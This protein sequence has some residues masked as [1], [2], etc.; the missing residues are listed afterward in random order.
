MSTWTPS[1]L[2]KHDLSEIYLNG[3]ELVSIAEK[4]QKKK[5]SHVLEFVLTNTLVLKTWPYTTRGSLTLTFIIEVKVT[6]YQ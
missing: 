5:N 1:Y 3:D 6:L 4:A 2:K